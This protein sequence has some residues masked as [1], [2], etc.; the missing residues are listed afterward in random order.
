[1]NMTSAAPSQKVTA[2]ALAGT[3][4]AIALFLLNYYVL[5]DRPLPDFLL[6]TIPTWFGSVVSY[7]VRP[8]RE[9]VAAVAP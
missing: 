2:G 6:T 4:M 3:G 9:D 1:M 5:R 8:S 7:F